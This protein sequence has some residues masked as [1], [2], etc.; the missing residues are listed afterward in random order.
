MY[1]TSMGDAAYSEPPGAAPAPSVAAGTGSA[2]RDFL[3]GF[4][5]LGLL[6]LA[7]YFGLKASGDIVVSI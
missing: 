6:L 4:V 7:T 2:I 5:I 1:R 3:L